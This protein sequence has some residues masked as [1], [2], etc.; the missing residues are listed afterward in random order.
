M[1]QDLVWNRDSIDDS[2]AI[3]T[4]SAPLIGRLFN[5]VLCDAKSYP[6]IMSGDFMLHDNGLL[7]FLLFLLLDIPIFAAENAY[8][9]IAE[10]SFSKGK[11]AGVKE[12]PVTQA[13]AANRERW[14]KELLRRLEGRYGSASAYFASAGIS[15]ATR[16][17]IKDVLLVSEEKI[18]VDIS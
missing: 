6:L 15:K 1:A 16:A 3:L 14:V 5:D 13:W 18:L 10:E 7:M 17:K 11:E 2:F 8:M 4:T 9:R 12:T